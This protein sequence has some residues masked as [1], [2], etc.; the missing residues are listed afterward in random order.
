M[1]R[2]MMICLAV[3]GLL[4]CTGN[5]QAQS[6]SARRVRTDE[7]VSAT[8]RRAV[9]RNADSRKAVPLRPQRKKV[10]NETVRAIE[11][12]NFDSNRLKMADM[13]FRTGGLMTTGQIEKIAMSFDFD[14]E[15]VKFLKMAY[16]NCLDPHMYYRVLRT[17]E[18]NSSREKIIDYVLDQRKEI[19]KDGEPYYKISSADM[20][21]IIKTLKNESFDSTRKKLAKMIVCGSV[22]TSRQIADMA[23][24]FD[25]DNNRYDFLLYASQSCIDMHNYTVAVNTLDFD[26][27]RRRLMDKVVRRAR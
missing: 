4:L 25:F 24:T 3:A 14:N 23:K 15:R 1:K 16:N 9:T 8:S 26:D 6:R 17:I 21:A 27:N 10:D 2:N 7:P 18:F 19:I 12:E 5:I 20:S 22:L 11:R 13:V